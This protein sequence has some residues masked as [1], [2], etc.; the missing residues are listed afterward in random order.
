MIDF[1]SACFINW[2]INEAIW[3]RRHGGSVV[4]ASDL[5]PG[6]LEFQALASDLKNI[7]FLDITLNSHSASFHPGV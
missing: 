1:V 5:R 7:V 2:V 3:N 4:S 6:G